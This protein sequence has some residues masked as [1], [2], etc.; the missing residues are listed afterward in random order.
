MTAVQRFFLG[1]TLWL[2]TLSL[3]PFFMNPERAV[4]IAL[5]EGAALQ[6]AFGSWE[7]LLAVR[8]TDG[9]IAA[10]T[11]LTF[12]FRLLYGWNE[13]T[14]WAGVNAAWRVGEATPF[15]ASVEGALRLFVFRWGHLLA[16]SVWF[17][18]C[19]M[20]GFLDGWVERRIRSARLVAPNP[21]R[22]AWGFVVLPWA[23]FLP[24]FWFLIPFVMPAWGYAMIPVVAYGGLRMALVNFH[25][26]V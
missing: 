23:F 2:V 21:V 5:L 19:G 10:W 16:L 14:W 24:V 1:L 22:F 20:F 17:L 3:L 25:R 11:W 9:L 15:Y 26:F 18:P 6:H 7:G 4:Q 13:T 8:I 12:P